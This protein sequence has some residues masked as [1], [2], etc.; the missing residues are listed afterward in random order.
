MESMHTHI[1]TIIIDCSP[2]NCPEIATGEAIANESEYLEAFV[3]YF[4]ALDYAVYARWFPIHI[5]HEN[6]LTRIQKIISTLLGAACLSR[7]INFNACDMTK[8]ND[9]TK[10]YCDAVALTDYFLLYS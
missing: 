7:T 6:T 10:N 8:N 3:L 5:R 4:C 2:L 1:L 9:S